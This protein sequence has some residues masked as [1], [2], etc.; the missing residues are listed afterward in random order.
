[1]ILSSCCRIKYTY[2]VL[3][4]ESLHEYN[5]PHLQRLFCERVVLCNRK[6]EKKK[7]KKIKK[8]KKNP[9]QPRCN[10][11]TTRELLALCNGIKKDERD[12]KAASPALQKTAWS[13]LFWS[14]LKEFREQILLRGLWLFSLPALVYADICFTCE[15][16]K[17]VVIT[18]KKKKKWLSL[19]CTAKLPVLHYINV[20]MSLGACVCSIHV[21]TC[22]CGCLKKMKA[23]GWCVSEY[24]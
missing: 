2:T 10:F 12:T 17:V 23:R 14:E 13:Q 8:K 19:K 6:K 20:R 9:Q 21:G 1:M 11:M 22:C 24:F 18:I 4:S 5:S 15:Q 16:R 3:A 7:G